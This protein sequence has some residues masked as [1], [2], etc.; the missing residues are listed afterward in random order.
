M[1][2]TPAL[3]PQGFFYHGADQAVQMTSINVL[4]TGVTA[5]QCAAVTTLVTEV[6]GSIIAWQCRAPEPAPI[7]YIQLQRPAD[8]LNVYT[9]EG[10]L[11]T[12]NTMVGAVLPTYFFQPTNKGYYNFAITLGSF[13]PVAIILAANQPVVQNTVGQYVETARIQVPGGQEATVIISTIIALNTVS[14]LPNTLKIDFMGT[15]VPAGS[16]LLVSL[17]I[18]ISTNAVQT[19]GVGQGQAVSGVPVS[20][21]LVAGQP[22]AVTWN[23]IHK[24]K[25]YGTVLITIPNIGNSVVLPG[26]WISPVPS[27][28]DQFDSANDTNSISLYDANMGKYTVSDDP[29]FSTLSQRVDHFGDMFTNLITTNNAAHKA[30][31]AAI[32]AKVAM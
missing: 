15:E 24:T 11:I 23:S 19:M 18:R 20:I 31:L 5:T 32:G 21:S 17:P 29:S 9:P 27:S 2:S 28:L 1:A 8:T 26:V 12:L 16:S 25:L 13:V 14:A 30:I 10:L 4:I 3:Q 7:W 6:A 22:Y